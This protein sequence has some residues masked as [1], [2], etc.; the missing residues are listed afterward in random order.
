MTDRVV[1]VLEREEGGKIRVHTAS[2]DDHKLILP[3]QALEVASVD[4]Q[5]GLV[6]VAKPG[7][8]LDID[9]TASWRNA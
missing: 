6:R 2:W 1:V 9:E 4:K 3:N 7:A 5:V 8:Y